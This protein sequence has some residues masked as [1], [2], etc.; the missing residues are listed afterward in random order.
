LRSGLRVEFRHTDAFQRYDHDG[1]VRG[2]SSARGNLSGGL[3]VCGSAAHAG[4]PRH[5]HSL[6]QIRRR[7]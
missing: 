6:Q 5:R 4:R 2:F 3:P 1:M 7:L